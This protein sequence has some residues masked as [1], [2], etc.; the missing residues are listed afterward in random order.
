MWLFEGGAA[1]IPSRTPRLVAE[2]PVHRAS[3]PA[4]QTSLLSRL[5]VRY[6]D[7]EQ[8]SL[9]LQNQT[10]SQHRTSMERRVILLAFLREG[11]PVYSVNS[12]TKFR[13]LKRHFDRTLGVASY[14]AGPAF[15]GLQD[16]ASALHK[17]CTSLSIATL[18]LKN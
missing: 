14:H 5:T 4:A 13:H 2:P 17:R 10:L 8:A 16:V 11:T 3:Q 7:R 1:R 12:E 15:C 9:L 18:T 6:S